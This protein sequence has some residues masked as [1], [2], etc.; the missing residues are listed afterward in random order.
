MLEKYQQEV[1][2]QES[3]LW[4]AERAPLLEEL[5]DELQKITATK[6]K[7]DVM[8]LQYIYVSYPPKGENCILGELPEVGSDSYGGNMKSIVPKSYYSFS[9]R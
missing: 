4:N 3:D 2:Q 9:S 7:G 8:F 1:V 5:K 6:T